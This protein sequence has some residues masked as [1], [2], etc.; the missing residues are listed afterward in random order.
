MRRRSRRRRASACRGNSRRPPRG[1]LRRRRSSERFVPNQR[2]ADGC[3]V[4]LRRALADARRFAGIAEHQCRQVARGRAG[5]RPA[6]CLRRRTP[7]RRDRV[8][9]DRRRRVR[10]NAARR[11]CRP[12]V[13]PS[14]RARVASRPSRTSITTLAS[15]NNDCNL[16]PSAAAP[17]KSRVGLT[18]SSTRSG[19]PAR[20]SSR[21]RA[22]V[23]ASLT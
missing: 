21:Q 17:G 9:P 22:T 1:S 13:P 6:G 16:S 20:G 8:P 4:V 5:R 11:T 14:N 19:D 3:V 2:A 15:L 7:G 10:R 23:S 12:I 18:T